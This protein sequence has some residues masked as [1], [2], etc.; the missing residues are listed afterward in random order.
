MKLITLSLQISNLK[1]I[2][3]VITNSTDNDTKGGRL[4]HFGKLV[5]YMSFFAKRILRANVQ[6]LLFRQSA[7]KA[8]I[9][10]LDLFRGFLCHRP[11]GYH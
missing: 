8:A 9:Y 3:V 5:T 1:N 10:H 4:Q 2:F 6:F 7:N 11:D